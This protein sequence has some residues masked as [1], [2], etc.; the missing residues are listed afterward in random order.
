MN[1]AS[2]ITTDKHSKV[3]FRRPKCPDWR[4]CCPC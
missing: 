2:V 3:G 4:R 1:S